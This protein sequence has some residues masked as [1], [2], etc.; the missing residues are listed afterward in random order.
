MEN[1]LFDGGVRPAN[2]SALTDPAD[3]DCRVHAAWVAQVSK[4]GDGMLD[5]EPG[6]S[7]SVSTSS[8]PPADRLA[9]EEVRR[10]GARR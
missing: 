6:G 7:T 8:S 3:P 4:A 10:A 9:G 5:K 2:T 1:E